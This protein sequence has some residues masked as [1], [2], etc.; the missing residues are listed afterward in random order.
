MVLKDPVLEA[1]DA[2]AA[3]RAASAPGAPAGRRAYRRSLSAA[4]AK[5]AV[6]A[7]AVAL[8]WVLTA[9]HVLPSFAVP[10][11]SAVVSAAES[12]WRSLLAQAGGT[13]EEVLVAIAA[14]WAVGVTAGVLIG[15]TP[16]LWPLLGL[17]RALYAVPIIVVYPLLSVWFG[18]GP[19]SKVVFGFVA[20]VIPMSLMCA[21]AVRSVD[22]SVFLLFS[23]LG[24][25]RMTMFRRG[26]LPAAL[27]GVVGAMRL[28]GSLGLVSVIIGEMLL[29]SKGVGYWIANAATQFEGPDLYAGVIVVLVF[30]LAING[31][32]GFFEQRISRIY[33]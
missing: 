23:S 1:R 4:G 8:W 32:V 24:A 28:S 26:V 10:T 21:A 31:L 9:L 33:G 2:P 15:M 14:I 22:D 7:C 17:G 5:I 16:R 20:G 25:S 3:D 27:P 12:S 11:P 13:A 18:V 6:L 30:A 29:A 19:V